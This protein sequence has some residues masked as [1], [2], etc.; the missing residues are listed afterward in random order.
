[1]LIS[2]NKE[3][4]MRVQECL[5]NLAKVLGLRGSFISLPIFLLTPDVLG[6]LRVIAINPCNL[7]V[8]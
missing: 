7:V 4:R 6:D 1:M 2:V 8:I 3:Y 5:V